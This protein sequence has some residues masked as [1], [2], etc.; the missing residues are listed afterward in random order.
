MQTTN[1]NDIQAKAAMLI[2]RPVAEV[3]EAF[4]DPAVTTNFWFTKGSGRLEEGGQVTWTWEMYNVSTQVYVKALK[5]NQRILIE[6]GDPGE[7]STVEWTFTPYEG[8]S[9]FVSITNF[10]FQGDVDSV[11]AQ[12]L[13]A[14]G[15]F[16][17]VLAGAKAYL[18]HHIRL[19][20]IAD[21]FPAGL[22]TH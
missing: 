20:L 12:A 22:T 2:R 14:T 7:S 15:G 17:W 18:E 13:D 6:W 1:P 8:E 5:A 4:V 9:T 3:F 21:R 11:I 16:S 10:G 19:N